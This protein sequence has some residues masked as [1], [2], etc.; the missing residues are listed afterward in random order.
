[1]SY[2]ESDFPPL[3][4]W[5]PNKH[6]VETNTDTFILLSAE[7]SIALILVI[8]LPLSTAVTK[9]IIFFFVCQIIN[10]HPSLA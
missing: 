8:P 7:F 5:C 3:I 9:L 1:M 6:Y 4:R 10:D 2:L